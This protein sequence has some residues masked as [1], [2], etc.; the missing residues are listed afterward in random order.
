MHTQDFSQ[1]KPNP[2]AVAGEEGRLLR[3]WNGQAIRVLGKRYAMNGG[4]VV[5]AREAI[6]VY[7]EGTFSE[8]LIALA[9]AFWD[10]VH[11]LKGRPE[12][13]FWNPRVT[14]FLK[15][16]PRLLAETAPP[17]ARHPDSL[18]TQDEIGTYPL[19]DPVYTTEPDATGVE[20]GRVA[21]ADGKPIQANPFPFEPGEN[22][23]RTIRRRDWSIGWQSAAEADRQQKEAGRRPT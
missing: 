19:D 14:N 5:A 23:D 1:E 4:D 3:A 7:G 20:R 10:R 15:Q 13:K 2:R 12:A 16:I 8:D 17:E 21:F 11:A 6:K 9:A 22:T 18:V